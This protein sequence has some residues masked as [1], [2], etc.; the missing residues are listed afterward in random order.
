MRDET[1]IDVYTSG[2]TGA[3]YDAGMK[4][5][6]S[7]KE[8]IIPILQMTV[9]EFKMCSQEE[10]LQCL[11]ISSITKDD[12][13]SDIPNI[14]KDLRLAKEESELSSLVEKLVRFDIRFKIKNPQLS[15]EKIRV[16]LHIDMEAQRSYRPSNPSYPVLKRAVYY[17]ARD[18]SAQLS[19]ITQVTDYSK[20]EKCYSI[21]ICT[22]D[23]PKKLQNTLTE[24]SLSKKDI[25]GETDEPDEDYDLLTVILIRQGKETEEKGILNLVKAAKKLSNIPFVFAGK[26]ELENEVNSADNIKN[27]GFKTGDELR[28]IIEKALFTV[29][30]AE[31]SENC[32]FSVMESQSLMTPV[33]G[34]KIGGIPELINDGKTGIL[35]ESGNLKELTEKI[36]YLYNNKELCRQMSENCRDIKYD[37]I[38]EYS[39]KLIKLYKEVTK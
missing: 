37:T 35:F 9:P 31:W 16:N 27:V 18:L 3:E 17:V 19:N 39:E 1:V 15:T 23:I 26:G 11:D 14:E 5:L 38:K 30:P 21:W 4:Q 10:I 24:Y 36:E 13:V 2:V 32:P 28:N 20:L 12:F 33:L 34:A 29:L 6:M 7:N 22:E 25:I 8:I